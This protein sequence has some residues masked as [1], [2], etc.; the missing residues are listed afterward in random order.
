M[1][2]AVAWIATAVAFAVLDAIWLSNAAPKIYRPLIGDMLMD[3]MRLGPAIAFYLI[4][5]SGL[6]FFAVS[7]ALEK[8]SLLSAVL[9]GAAFG[10]VA[11]A[12]YDL[13]NHATLKVWDI[14]MTLIDMAWG[15]IASALA[16]GAGFWAAQRFS[17]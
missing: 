14:R 4:Y 12:T 5:V 15:T 8:N 9:V 7:P 2:Y 3:G 6:T 17:G 16:A 1:H 10:F 13:T 11:Y